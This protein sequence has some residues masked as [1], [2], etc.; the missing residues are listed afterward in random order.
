MKGFIPHQYPHEPEPLAYLPA[1]TSMTTAIGEAMTVSAG[2]LAKATG[3]AAPEYICTS[4]NV[5]VTAGTPI[6]CQ[7]VQPGVIYETELTVAITGLAVGNKYTIGTDS[8]SIT[9]TTTD[10]VAKVV[11]FDGTAAGSKVYVTFA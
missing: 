9:S 8:A 3:T 2:A 7:K 6:A 10:G 5:G 4:V 1:A 11:A